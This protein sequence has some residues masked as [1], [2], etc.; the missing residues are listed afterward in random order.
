VVCI[1]RGQVKDAPELSRE[2]IA[3]ASARSVLHYFRT[4]DED[5]VYDGLCFQHAHMLAQ[6]LAKLEEQKRER[7]REK[8][9]Q[10]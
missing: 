7:E 2:E 4:L 8:E 9:M 6:G 10:H 3:D 1:C 5:I